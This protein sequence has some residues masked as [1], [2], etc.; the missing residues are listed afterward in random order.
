[1]RFHSLTY[2][3]FLA[4]V[5]LVFALLP[6][7]RLRK[8][9]LLGA[10][11][12][13]YASWHWPYL[14]LLFGAVS[15]NHFGAR[16]IVAAADRRRRG[17]WVLAANLLLLA[18]FKY[19]DWLITTWNDGAALIGLESDLPVVRLVLPLGIS[20][21]LFQA[22]SYIIDLMRKRERLH[23]FWDL[24]LYI[25]YFPQLI[26]G[27]IMRAKEFL[28]QLGERW[29]VT[30][31]DVRLGLRLIVTGLVVKIV[32]A[33]GLAPQVD[34]AFAR[35][36][37]ALSS[38]DVWVM[39]VAFGLQI[40]FD[41]SAYSRIAIGSARLC[42]LRLVDNFD[43]PYSATSPADFWARWH[44]SLSRW[45]RDYLFF[46]LAGGRPGLGGLCRA[47]I[48]AMTLCGLWHGAGWTFVLWGLYHGL[49]ISGY[50][51]LRARQARTAPAAKE[52]AAW[53]R[54]PAILVTFALV[55]LG[56]LLFRS[57]D[58]TQAFELLGRAT[59]PWIGRS[60]ALSGTFYLHTA[61][62]ALAVWAMPW[63]KQFGSRLASP[64]AGR[65]PG[66]TAAAEGAGLGLLLTL[67]LI[68]L[69]SQTSF[70]YFQF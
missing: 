35:A 1:M 44:M 43:F 67:C 38:L 49:L 65:P 20:F 59:S 50:H 28:P 70:I 55:S 9:W 13:F 58:L 31:E 2:W 41:F 63:L 4:V 29:R 60:R 52:V 61:L 27:P 26:A 8:G 53:R 6:N 68:Y 19:L 62:L 45:I 3:L 23:S 42:G 39:A 10:S 15:L 16:W 17:R 56:W 36:P 22:I 40:Y 66:W 37:E 54:G 33:D 7:R 57:T 14:L 18:I 64:A 47:A 12:A 24:Q 32:L 11:Y 34:R 5:C 51:L 46:P 30:A 48:L 25:A 69:R 21:Y